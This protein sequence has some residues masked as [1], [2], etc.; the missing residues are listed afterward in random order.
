[1]DHPSCR[2]IEFIQSSKIYDMM[3]SD[4]DDDDDDEWF[5]L[6]CLVKLGILGGGGTYIH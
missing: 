5:L 2:I 3:T 1:M 6:V 4:L